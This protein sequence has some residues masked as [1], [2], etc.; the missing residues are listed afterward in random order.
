MKTQKQ[1]RKIQPASKKEE[2]C[3]LVLFESEQHYF[4]FTLRAL[5]LSHSFLNR[6]N[7]LLLLEMLHFTD[8]Q[9]RD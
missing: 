8:L 2:L 4:L 3:G 9:G 5:C 7:I 6:K 1:Y